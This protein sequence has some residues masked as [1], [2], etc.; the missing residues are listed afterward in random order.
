MPGPT[1]DSFVQVT[2][3]VGAPAVSQLGPNT[4]VRGQLGRVGTS[5]DFILMS[6]PFLFAN[7]VAPNTRTLAAGVPMVGQSS[8]GIVYMPSGIPLP[9]ITAAAPPL[10]TAADTRLVST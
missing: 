1:I 9:P 3:P 2:S 10:V 8:L 7:W 5:V 4:R 6:P